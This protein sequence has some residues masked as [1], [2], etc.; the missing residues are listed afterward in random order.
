MSPTT[1]SLVKVETAQGVATLT[2]SRPE[3]LNSIN[4]V[5]V[6]QLQQA[7]DE[8]VQ[9]QAVRGIV[10][11][12]E[13][14]V[15]V[16]GA[17]LGFFVRNVESGNLERIVQFTQ[18]GQRLFNVIDRCPKPVVARLNGTA[19]GGGAELALACDWIVASPRAGL[20]FPETGLGIYPALGG[21]QRLPRAIG[22]GL[23]KWLIF[24]GKTLSAADA[25]KIG[26]VDR[27][28]PEEQLEAEARRMALSPLLDER[29]ATPPA[30]FAAI[31]RFF[32]D[33]PA[34]ALRTG[35]ANTQG[36]STLERTM[37]QVANKAPIALRVAEKLIDQGSRR[38]LDEGLRMEI[39]NLVAIYSTQDAYRGLASRV[40]R[41]ISQPVFEGR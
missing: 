35:T 21:T 26:L 28:V 40:Q 30:E 8:A 7:F 1:L 3:M 22:G 38:T 15:F 24:T 13:G 19:L 33:N 25:A 9:D 31:A 41:Q 11:A 34:D 2:I 37:R 16:A 5:V 23:A 12:G 14:K 17:D 4:P 6:Y 10:I 18:A 20:G 27:V 39:E 36:D 32:A 29:P